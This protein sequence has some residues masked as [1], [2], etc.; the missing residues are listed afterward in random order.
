MI[1]IESDSGTFHWAL[2]SD[3]DLIQGWYGGI[4]SF[5]VRCSV[6][7]TYPVHCIDVQQSLPHQVPLASAW[8]VSNS[9]YLPTLYLT[10]PYQQVIQN[11]EGY[12][13]RLSKDDD[14]AEARIIRHL[15]GDP[16]YASVGLGLKDHL[17]TKHGDQVS[18][19][20]S[21]YRI[22]EY[23]ALRYGSVLQHSW[24]L[25]PQTISQLD[26]LPR[27]PQRIF[28]RL[29]N[30]H[31][32]VGEFEKI[33][34]T[35]QEPRQDVLTNESNIPR[36]MAHLQHLGESYLSQR[37]EKIVENFREASLHFTFL[38]E[39]AASLPRSLPDIPHTPEDV[40]A[41][42][43]P[44][45][46][47]AKY[48]IGTREKINTYLAHHPPSQ[49]RLPFQIALL[50]SMLV[51]LLPMSLS[52]CSFPRGILNKVCTSF[53]PLCYFLYSKPSIDLLCCWKPAARNLGPHRS[54]DLEDLIHH[55]RGLFLVSNPQSIFRSY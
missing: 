48:E 19:L 15:L 34:R 3:V 31:S 42:V 27:S 33:V 32:I 16:L 55:Q 1:H 30:W 23:E 50:I 14:H 47:L 39:T 37:I 17:R 8:L 38:Q 9:V 25:V 6:L 43:L 5:R 29:K 49:I 24:P 54:G 51:L 22:L 4:V 36:T 20:L 18:A 13:E 10:M 35:E 28:D 7:R 21:S 26:V 44:E 46:E 40:A 45:Q 2:Y 11:V 53:A 41:L 52:K 12:E